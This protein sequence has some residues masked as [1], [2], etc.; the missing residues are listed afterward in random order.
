[1]E[2]Q[3]QTRKK[4]GLTESF[5]LFVYISESFNRSETKNKHRAATGS[6]DMVER[7]LRLNGLEGGQKVESCDWLRV[8]NLIGFGTRQA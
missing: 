7:R 6:G 5:D 1:M 3:L 4:T 8:M 2:T